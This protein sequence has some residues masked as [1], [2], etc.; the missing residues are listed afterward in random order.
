MKSLVV[1]PVY[2]DKRFPLQKQSL[3]VA[4]MEQHIKKT[5]PQNFDFFEQKCFFLKGTER[6]KQEKPFE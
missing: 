3:T 6:L 5:L 4:L 1:R 2:F